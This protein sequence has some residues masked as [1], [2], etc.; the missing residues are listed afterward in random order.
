[1]YSDQADH[2]TQ[3][4]APAWRDAGAAAREPT[5]VHQPVASGG[6][7]SAE[8]LLACGG[9]SGQIVVGNIPRQPPGFQRPTDLMAD[10][11]RGGAGV[12]VL[13]AVTEMRGV[14]KTQLAAAYARA[15]LAEG[16]RL[17]AW[18]NAEN[19]GSLLGGLAAVADAAGLSD[20]G[21]RD[22]G[23]AV[24]HRLEADGERSL[25]VF[26]D[27]EDPAALRPFVPTCGAA[28]VLITTTRQSVADMGIGV[29]VD[30]FSTDEA[31][32][33][34]EER[35]GLG[36]E[37][38]A[39]AVAAE[40]GYLPLALAQAATVVADQQLGYETY[41]QR[42]RALPVEEYLTLEQSQPYPPGSAKAV[43]L[44]LE[45]VQA[46]DQMGTCTGVMEITAVLS[47]DG[48][49]RDLLYA[50]G[51]AGLLASGGHRVTAALV[52]W[53]L[54]Q[55]AERS[56]A[57]FS[58]DG[59]TIIVHRL[60][61]RVVRDGMARRD[62]LTAACRVA[63]SVL[64]A[65][66]GRLVSLHDRPVIR[67][68]AKQVTALDSFAETAAEADEELAR[69]MLRL[70]FLALYHLI[71][72]GDSTP[73][74]IVVG[75]ALTAD[76]KRVLGP[77]HPDTLNAWNS[78]AAAY[79]A[80][81][82]VDEAIRLF[83]L[84]LVGRARVLGPGHPDTL[85]SQNNLAA[86]YQDAGRTAEAIRL[87]EL[88]LAAREQVLGANHPS[89]LNS[90][91]NL[92][93]AYRDTGRIAE[94][95]RL[96]ELTLAARERVLGAHHPDTLNSRNNLASA[97][98][99]AGHVSEAI[100][101]VEQ[102][103]AVRERMLGPHHPSTLGARNNLAAAYRD[104]GRAAEA[105]RLHE[106]TLAACERLLGADHPTT[107]GARN[108]LANAYRDAGRAAEAIRLHE[109]TLTARERVLGADHASTLA[110]RD[111]LA[112]AYRSAGRAAEAIP[113]YELTLTARERALGCDHP[114]TLATRNS[115]ALA[116]Q[117]AGRT[118]EAMLLFEQN[119]VGQER[120][121]GTDH[122]DTLATRNSLALACQ[123][124]SGAG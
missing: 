45:A 115:L 2:D 37:A 61:M 27:V 114:D 66:A 77:G 35:T 51:R 83:E 10:L 8:D 98:R 63:A 122:P 30:V 68:L 118:V 56:L 109:Q 121:L 16:W 103:L 6:T 13:H 40:V 7:V 97:Y 74:A 87:F 94:A 18:V 101:L 112:D 108:N 20:G 111:H 32:D 89:T 124:A 79:Q 106:Q 96:F 11:D 59:Q 67:D 107:L 100:P 50:A 76:L 55:L 54:E 14:G 120:V 23:Q 15:K 38:G 41:L 102:I 49:D 113:L 90:R 123:E 95:I 88:T 92:A 39:A 75:E 42:L 82:R 73:Q 1:M 105:I 85:T 84:T 116:C 58:L 70:R 48:V 71:E 60:V 43:L 22:P 9:T 86:T 62:R 53:A 78:L 34:L 104:V 4:E 80:A 93:A 21:S 91:G 117:E 28:R 24:R 12:A 29:P 64:E 99:D 44:A 57:T 47:A 110:T 19:A 46:S 33:F 52:S 69:I 81:D 65:R 72:L 119:L 3:Q 25:L 26:D 17:V 36:D 31:L 5:V